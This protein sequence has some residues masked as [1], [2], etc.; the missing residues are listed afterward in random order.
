MY[1]NNVVAECS[2]CSQCP[3]NGSLCM[4]WH[5]ENITAIA[6]MLLS[7]WHRANK[8]NPLARKRSGCGSEHLSEKKKD[9]HHFQ[10]PK[11]EKEYVCRLKN[12][13]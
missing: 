3:P 12:C 9:S 2:L 4:P 8:F 7:S 5:F 13:K 1:S 11:P 10:E 6:A